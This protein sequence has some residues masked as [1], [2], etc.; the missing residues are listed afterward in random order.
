MSDLS[1][2]EF[3]KLNV[4]FDESESVMQEPSSKTPDNETPGGNK[5]SPQSIFSVGEYVLVKYE[6]GQAYV[7]VV[8][9]KEDDMYTVAFL[10]CRGQPFFTLK[11]N[12]TDIIGRECIVGKLEEP[13]IS[14]RGYFIFSSTKGISVH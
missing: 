10:E 12:D 5:D 7:A 11:D 14:S 2:Q 13:T 9:A 6:K 1:N 4:Q 3:R 8:Q